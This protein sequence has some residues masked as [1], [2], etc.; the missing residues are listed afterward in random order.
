MRV[1]L[2]GMSISTRCGGGIIIKTEIDLESEGRAQMWGSTEKD[3]APEKS[4]D[5]MCPQWEANREINKKGWV[6]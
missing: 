1:N 6:I 3:E 4:T 5:S 2:R